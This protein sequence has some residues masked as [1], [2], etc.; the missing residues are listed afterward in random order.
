MMPVR[1]MMMVIIIITMSL[2]LLRVRLIECYVSCISALYN[3]I[4]GNERYQNIFF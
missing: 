3:D 4:S 2:L 1:L